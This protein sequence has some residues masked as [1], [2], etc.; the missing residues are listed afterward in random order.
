[1]S[2]DPDFAEEVYESIVSTEIDC[3]VLALV[4]FEF[5]ITLDQE[6]AIVWR[7]KFTLTS[8]LV[9]AIRWS[10]VANV[11]LDWTPASTD[12]MQSREQTRER[13]HMDRLWRHRIILCIAGLSN[14]GSQLVLVCP[15]LQS[16][17]NTNMDKHLHCSPFPVRL[18][19]EV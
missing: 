13:G 17:D 6:V 7:R 2:V 14:M 5:L 8:A 18:H 1:M 3:G 11:V 16:G 9:V 19:R 12:L 10:M 4:A 15:D